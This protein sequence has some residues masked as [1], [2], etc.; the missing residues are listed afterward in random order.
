MAYSKTALLEKALKIAK[1]HARSGNNTPIDVVLKQVY[2][3]LVEINEE[4][5]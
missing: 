2:E 4:L 1:A 3:A 5:K